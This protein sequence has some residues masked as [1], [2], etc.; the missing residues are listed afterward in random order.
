MQEALADGSLFAALRRQ[1]LAVIELRKAN[2]E[3]KKLGNAWGRA[4]PLH[5]YMN[6]LL[7]TRDEPGR[8]GRWASQYLVDAAKQKIVTLEEVENA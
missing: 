3:L 4:F 5:G 1:A 8:V 2:A 6:F 7:G